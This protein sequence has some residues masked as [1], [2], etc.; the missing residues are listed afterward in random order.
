MCPVDP[1]GSGVEWFRRPSGQARKHYV[2]W[3]SR[4]ATTDHCSVAV[5]L[6]YRPIDTMRTIPRITRPRQSRPGTGVAAD[7]PISLKKSS[8]AFEVFGVELHYPKP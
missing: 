8:V 2:K 7:G 6:L 5:A 1:L 3:S 4:D